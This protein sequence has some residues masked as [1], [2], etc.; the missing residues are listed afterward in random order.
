MMDKALELPPRTKRTPIWG[1][2]RRRSGNRLSS[3]ATAQFGPRE[4]ARRSSDPQSTRPTKILSEP[5]DLR[6]L[7]LSARARGRGSPA[8][9]PGTGGAA[10]EHEPP[11][12]ACARARPR[13]LQCPR[14]IGTAE[15]QRH[16]DQRLRWREQVSN[17]YLKQ[18]FPRLHL[19]GS[20]GGLGQPALACPSNSSAGWSR[21]IQYTTRFTRGF[22]TAF[23]VAT[24]H[25]APSDQRK[26][27]T[28]RFL[29]RSLQTPQDVAGTR[30]RPRPRFTT[31]TEST[32]D[33]VAARAAAF[34]ASTSPRTSGHRLTGCR[35]HRS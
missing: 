19:S 30:R 7:I 32:R 5:L 3:S 21:R 27:I 1:S 13:R 9:A 23:S 31:S 29:R 35:S 8:P 6:A 33:H 4:R 11:S 34:R 28:Y 18:V 10:M 25:S 26:Q 2:S 24:C 14:T 15:A 20:P 22:R 12:P 16:V 17:R